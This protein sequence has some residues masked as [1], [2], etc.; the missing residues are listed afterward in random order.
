MT[1]GRKGESGAISA[2]DRL[3]GPS[4]GSHAATGPDFDGT[5]T[6]SIVFIHFRTEGRYYGGA[7]GLRVISSGEGVS[8]SDT[9]P[10]CPVELTRQSGSGI[11]G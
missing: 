5:Y 8:S 6:H 4:P 3:S 1:D 7:C 2:H 10:C 9:E 11:L